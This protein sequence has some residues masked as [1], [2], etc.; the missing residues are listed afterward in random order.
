MGDIDRRTLFRAGAATVVTA[1]ACR[2]KPHEAAPPIVPS[3]PPVVPLV[4]PL[5]VGPGMTGLPHP[6]LAEQSIAE[7]AG[8]L[9]R[10]ELTSVELVRRYRERIAALDGFLHSVLELDRDAEAIAAQ[11]DSERAAGKVRGPLHGIPILVK[12]NID[13]GDTMLTTAGS[14]ALAAS[15][16]ARRDAFVIGQLRTAGAIILGKTNMSEWANFRGFTSVSGWSARG[17]QCRNPYA[18]D[19]TPSGSSSGS[20]VATAAGLCAAALGTETDGSIISPASLTALVGV[21]PTIGLVSRA[22]VIPISPSQDTVGPMARSVAD[23]ALLLAAIAGSDPEDPVTASCRLEDYSRHLDPKALAGA[24][25]GVPRKGWFGMVRCL[26]TIMAAA[27]DRL[28]ALGAVLVD[29]VELEVPPMPELAVLVAEIKPAMAAYLERRGDPKLRTLF[30]LILFNVQH[31][32]SELRLFGQEW[33]EKAASQPGTQT[34]GYA[35]A[36]AACLATAR[37]KLLDAALEQHHL[38]ALVMVSGGLP[39]LI[40]PIAGDTSPAGPSATTLP[41]VAGYPHVTVPAGAYHGLP[42]GMSFV[43]RPFSEAKLLGYAYAFEQAT[44]HRKPPRYYQTAPV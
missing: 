13:T 22:G 12:D 32:D 25:I 21:K 27:L 3:A 2:D 30:D 42:V 5:V 8:K 23:A 19:R 10:R 33:F 43:G 39:W 29:N 18:L 35:E 16:P 28:V 14:L 24:R 9:E 37:G 4:E 31:A 7:L 15:P 34:P 26:D 41:A 38:D 1:A 20:A 6:E 36:R 40:D 44:H 17:G 11:L